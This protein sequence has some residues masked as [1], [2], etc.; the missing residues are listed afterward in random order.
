MLRALRTRSG[1]APAPVDVESFPMKILSTIGGFL[2]LTSSPGCFYAIRDEFTEC[3]IR[4]E[5]HF[6][7]SAAWRAYRWEHGPVSCPHSFKEGFYAGY[8]DVSNGKTGCP[9]IMIPANCHSKMWLDMCS[10]EEKTC[11]WYN[12]YSAGVS[13]ASQD[14][15]EGIHQLPLRLSSPTAPGGPHADAGGQAVLGAA[16]SN[17]AMPAM[18]AMPADA[19]MALPPPAP[20]AMPAPIMTEQSPFLP[21][22]Q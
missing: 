12:G 4:I 13:I 2:L 14:G 3:H 20:A 17:P 7:A 10:Q 19:Q 18:S 15:S 8:S 5:D 9:P 6:A 21:P 22:I 1:L 16:D 11:A